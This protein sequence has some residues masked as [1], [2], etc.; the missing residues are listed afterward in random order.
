MQLKA[1]FIPNSIQKSVF[2]C[3]LARLLSQVDESFH[4]ILI[5]TSLWTK[6]EGNKLFDGSKRE[7]KQT[8]CA[9]TFVTLR[10][11]INFAL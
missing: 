6:F 3:I 2:S 7:R 10:Y 5:L 4:L 8:C 11:F 9:L 1:A